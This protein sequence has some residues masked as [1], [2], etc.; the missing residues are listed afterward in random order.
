MSDVSKPIFLHYS[1][2]FSIFPLRPSDFRAVWVAGRLI[3]RKDEKN[4]LGPTL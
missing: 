4:P 1:S 2:A 3:F